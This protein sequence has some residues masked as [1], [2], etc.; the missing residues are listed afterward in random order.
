V[1]PRWSERGS[2]LIHA[3][4]PTDPV[5]EAYRAV[6]SG[7]AFAGV[8]SPVHSLTV[9]SCAPGEGKSSL[10]MNLA[11]CLAYDGARVC[12]V[13]CDLRRPAQHRAF[14][15]LGNA[16]GLS[17]VLTGEVPLA[18]AVQETPI[19]G[20]SVLTSGPLPQNPGR[21]VESLRLRQVLQELGRTY[22]MVIIDAP[23]VLAV[24]DAVA[25]ARATKGTLLVVEAGVTTRRMLLDLRQRLDTAGIEPIGAVLAKVDV[26]DG[27]YGYYR[28]YKELYAR[29]DV[30]PD[31]AAGG[32]P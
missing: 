17:S 15:S 21:L 22:A 11:T 7:I 16:V 6:R 24:A 13:D 20:L 12:V 8:D 9:T 26:R 30:P 27:G 4:P 2:A 29:R 18:E 25:L 5:F 14:P 23:P 1:L 31:A 10:A 19:P 32:A 28:A 3:L